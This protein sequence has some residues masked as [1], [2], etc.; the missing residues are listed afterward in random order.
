LQLGCYDAGVSVTVLA[1]GD[2]IG[3]PGRDA[4]ARVLP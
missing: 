4:V 1:I 3:R 2:I